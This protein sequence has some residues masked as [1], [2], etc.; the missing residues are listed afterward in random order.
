M[1]I[2]E[3]LKKNIM[4]LPTRLLN[5]SVYTVETLAPS[6]HKVMYLPGSCRPCAV[7]P[8]TVC[9]AASQVFPL[10][11]RGWC[12]SCAAEPGRTAAPQSTGPGGPDGS[13]DDQTSTAQVS[14]HRFCLCLSW[15]MKGY[16]YT[17]I[18]KFD[19][20]HYNKNSSIFFNII[21]I[22]NDCFLFCYI[23]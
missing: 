16:T 22:W 15:S 23:F 14:K 10:V 17:A 1:S 19:V 3:I 4:I 6:V 7:D 9:R 5:W 13:T 20:W 21:T 11:S 2:R 18:Q 8:W 12:H